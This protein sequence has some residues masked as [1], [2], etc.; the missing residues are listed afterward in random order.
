MAPSNP[1]PRLA[2]LR[3]RLEAAREGGGPERIERQHA[4]EIGRAHV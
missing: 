4:D 1:D 2:E 3:A